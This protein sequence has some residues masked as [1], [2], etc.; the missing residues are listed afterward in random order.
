MLRTGV[1][2]AAL[3]VLPFYLASLVGREEHTADQLRFE[4][5]AA[6]QINTIRR[7]LMVTYD[8]L[9]TLTEHFEMTGDDSE[10]GF[11]RITTPL[12]RDHPYLQAIGLNPRVLLD[13]RADFEARLQHEIPGFVIR[14]AS[15][16]GTFSPAGKRAEYYPFLRVEPLANNRAA[17]GFDSLVNPGEIPGLQ[18]NERVAAVRRALSSGETA[19]TGP[20]QLVLARASGTTGVIAFSPIHTQDDQSVKGFLTLVIRIGDLVQ[21]A[22]NSV[23]K[24][25]HEIAI[26]LDD[27]SSV[28]PQSLHKETASAADFA[29][30][31]DI[32]LPD[33][34]I[35]RAVIT[36]HDGFASS[37]GPAVR[38]LT[39]GGGLFV[40][41]IL[42]MLLHSLNSRNRIISQRVEK[43]TAE[44]TKANAELAS[45][46]LRYQQILRTA[47]DLV[48]IFN[49]DWRLHE[50][51]DSF[52]AHLGYTRE[53]L[54]QLKVSDWDASFP[55]AV[56]YKLLEDMHSAPATFETR[57]RRKD[58]SLRDVE[59]FGGGIEI[60]GRRY[61]Y[62]SARDITEKKQTARELE[63]HRHHLEE[64]LA[65]RTRDLTRANAELRQAKDEAERANQAKSS[66][67]ANMS[68]EIRTP[69]N[70][71]T[72]MVHLIQRAGIPPEQA[73]RL[74]KINV[75][76][77]HLLDIINAILDL[78]KIEAGKFSI[79]ATDVHVGAVVANVASLLAQSAQEKHLQ[80]H[81]DSPPITA[82]LLGDPARLQQALLNYGSNA[83]KFTPRGSVALRTR[84]EEEREDCV[85]IRFE[86]EDTG[87]G[88]PPD[89]VDKLFS[90]FEQADN[91]IRRSYGGTGL[92]LVITR[93][94]AQLMGGDAGV[95][96]HPGSGSTFWFTAT[97]KKQQ[98]QEASVSAPT[99]V[100]IEG[101]ESLLL[102]EYG[103]RRLL[104][105]E[106]E[107]VNREVT[108][109]LLKDIWPEVA[110]ATNGLE[111]VDKAAQQSYDLILMDVQMPE[112]DGLEATRRIRA[113]DHDNAIPIIA[114]TANAFAEDKARCLDA[115]MNDFIAKPVD[116]EALFACLLEWLKRTSS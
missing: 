83:I 20:I 76:G 10:L 32:R 102:R 52:M 19:T 12:L 73:A 80:L 33:G 22:R 93:R 97:L 114:M 1:V 74:E 48:H 94:L 42:G 35:W 67:L 30:S 41:L 54:C 34:K 66:F 3:A 77:K 21:A 87:I 96:T 2:Y 109:E 55:E 86:V 107:P 4:Q 31:E 9:K 116:P 24:P 29:Y 71:I 70:A 112:L 62:C 40:S 113:L 91:S 38:W 16:T 103:N 82:A 104:L 39:L 17:Q 11:R 37:S 50:F 92:G 13:E 28:P 7:E 45:E 61:V 53:E 89:R 44:L 95:V 6:T 110:I 15:R 59:I 79:D 49:E 60:D 78:S 69:L 68:H 85:R 75:A 57:H 63:Q 111:A 46:R 108:L 65:D 72:G 26:T 84:L 51:S 47:T 98:R 36:A 5:L 100:T 14:E 23:G 88:I 115:G 81:I 58:G 90:P 105:V 106:D 43:Q 99:V 27:I 64:L 8:L 25:S 56:L 101:P 18:S